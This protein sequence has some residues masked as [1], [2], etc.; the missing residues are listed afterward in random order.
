MRTSSYRCDPT[1]SKRAN[2]TKLRKFQRTRAEARVRETRKRE[3]KTRGSK[4]GSFNTFYS[5]QF[6]LSCCFFLKMIILFLLPSL[7]HQFYDSFTICDPT[8]ETDTI[9]TCTWNLRMSFFLFFFL[10]FFNFKFTNVLDKGEKLTGKL[11]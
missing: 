7:Y 8:T 6:A 2:V 4:I 9:R 3:R 1:N 10:F 11:G 5:L